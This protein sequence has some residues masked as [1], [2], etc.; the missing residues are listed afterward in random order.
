MTKEQRRQVKEAVS[1]AKNALLEALRAAEEGNAPKYV[2]D[3]L[4]MLCGKTEALQGR[5][6]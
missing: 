1:D 3:R 6:S 4:N 2:L 5:L